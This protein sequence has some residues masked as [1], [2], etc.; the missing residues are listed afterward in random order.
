MEEPRKA[1]H[2]LSSRSSS[3]IDV[4]THVRRWQTATW[5]IRWRQRSSID[6]STYTSPLSWY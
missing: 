3:L 6:A 4:P 1:S 2:V 5:R